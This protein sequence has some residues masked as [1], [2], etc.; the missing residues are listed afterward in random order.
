MALV[1][2]HWLEADGFYQG[3]WK[4]CV[5]DSSEEICLATTDRGMLL[6]TFVNVGR[7]YKS[8]C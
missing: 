1:T 3:L 7:Y 5:A 4:Y 8:K 2:S 6:Y